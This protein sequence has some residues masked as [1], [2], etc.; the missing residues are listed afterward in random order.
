MAYDLQDHFKIGFAR[1]VFTVAVSE[2]S[3]VRVQVFDMNGQLLENFDEYVSGSRA[4]NLNYL[5]HGNYIVR[6][7]SSTAQRTARIVI[8]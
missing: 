4:F 5:E 7:W 1:N 6:V 3:S 2:P 8:R